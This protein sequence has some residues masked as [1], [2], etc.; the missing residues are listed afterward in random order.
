MPLRSDEI[1]D[2]TDDGYNVARNL[3]GGWSIE[4][5]DASGK[6]VTLDA[7]GNIYHSGLTRGSV[8]SP[9]QGEGDFY[10][11]RLLLEGKYLNNCK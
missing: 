5:A 10:L 7:Y 3:R 8:F 2:V 11:V 4:Q 9:Q 6:A 1:I